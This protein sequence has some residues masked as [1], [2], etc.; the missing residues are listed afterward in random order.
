MDRR[1]YIQ[2]DDCSDEPLE[3]LERCSCDTHVELVDQLR[4]VEEDDDAMVALDPLPVLEAEAHHLEAVSSS[5][6]SSFSTSVSLPL[7]APLLLSSQSLASP[8]ALFTPGRPR[9]HANHEATC[10]LTV[11]LPWTDLA[12]AA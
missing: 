6:A 12:L 2:P 11:C 1:I 10:R 7:P 9:E 3:T 5:F 4:V 8:R